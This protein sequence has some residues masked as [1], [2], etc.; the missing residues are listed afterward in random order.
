[1]MRTNTPLSMRMGKEGGGPLPSLS[2]HT[3]LSCALACIPLPFPSNQGS[4]RGR[5]RGRAARGHRERG[6][7][8]RAGPYAAHAHDSR[9][10]IRPSLPAPCG[11]P[12]CTVRDG[13]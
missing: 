13:E 6:G 1:M 2:K 4:P 8:K 5:G 12:H 3:F 11:A 7:K 10:P 9:I